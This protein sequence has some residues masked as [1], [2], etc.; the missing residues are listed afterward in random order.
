MPVPLL[1]KSPVGAWERA[2]RWFDHHYVSDFSSQI[3]GK[4]RAQQ[5]ALTLELWRT[6]FLAFDGMFPVF[7]H[8]FN[9]SESV[10]GY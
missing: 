5:M 9:L 8:T 7:D 1:A 2:F 3:L 4:F 6:F 10:H